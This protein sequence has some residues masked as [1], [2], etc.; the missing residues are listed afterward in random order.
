MESTTSFNINHAE[1]EGF[2]PTQ[3]LKTTDLRSVPDLPLRCIHVTN[4]FKW[5]LKGSNLV[6]SVFSGTHRPS[7]PKHRIK[8]GAINIITPILS[9]HLCF[10]CKPN[11]VS[12]PECRRNICFNPELYKVCNQLV[13]PCILV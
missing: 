1:E 9:V 8:I 12:M 7:L 13:N 3:F 4:Q 6:L 2:E 11:N 10:F 5:C